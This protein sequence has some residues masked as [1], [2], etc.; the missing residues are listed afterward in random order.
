M[1]D[2]WAALSDPSRRK[3]LDL[4]RV[5]NLTAG[6]IADK[7]DMT[8]PSISHHLSIL[9][10]AELVFA[11]KKGQQIEYSINTTVF[12]DILEFFVKFSEKEE[13]KGRD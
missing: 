2:V 10:Q 12:Q 5:Q 9:K 11:E 1:K 3:I 6:E 7:F 8:K 4:L 13:K